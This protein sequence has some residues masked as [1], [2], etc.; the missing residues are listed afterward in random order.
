M[1]E[2][3]CY[4]PVMIELYKKIVNCYILINNELKNLIFGYI[5]AVDMGVMCINFLRN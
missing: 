4:G 1:Q 3:Q 2:K 5:I